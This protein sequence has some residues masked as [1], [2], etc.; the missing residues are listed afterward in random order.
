MKDRKIELYDRKKTFK[1]NFKEVNEKHIV[2]KIS[3]NDDVIDIIPDLN[4]FIVTKPSEIRDKMGLMSLIVDYH[5]H[6]GLRYNMFKRYNPKFFTCDERIFFEGLLVKFKNADFREFEWAKDKIFYELG[7]K[8]SRLD[9]IIKKFKDLGIINYTTVYALKT[10]TRKNKALFFNVNPIKIMELAPKIY[11]Y[12]YTYFESVK[13][14]RKF[15]SPV[16]K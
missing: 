15:L 10:N 3:K 13:S 7:I 4:S 6:F 5:S 11:F 8:R 14:L 1:A 16:L 9:S 2:F 12:K